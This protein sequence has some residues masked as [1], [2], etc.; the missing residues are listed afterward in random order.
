MKI[1]IL[2]L[3]A[4]I[5]FSGVFIGY[6]FL[7][8]A[9]ETKN[10][11]WG[12]NF[13]QKQAQN[14]GLEW[15]ETY[16]A[17][18][19]DLKIKNL[20][21]ISHW[22]LIEPKQG[23]YNFE[24]LDWQVN[25]A[26]KRGVKILLVVGIKTGRWPEC[27]APEWA[28]AQNEKRKSQNYLLEY[29]G[30]I[31]KRYRG[32]ASVSSWQAENEPF[33]PFGE[34]SGI[35]KDFLKK[36]I[37]QIKSLD[38]QKR[39]VVISDSGEFSFWLAAAELG[40]RVGTTLHRKVWFKEL[41]TYIQYPLKPVFYWRRAQLIEKL[42]GKEVFVAELQAE[43]WCQVFLSDCKPKEQ[44]KTMNL[45][46]FRGNIE[47]AKKTGLS[48]VYLWGSEWWYWLKTEQGQSSIW[49]EAKKLF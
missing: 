48:E 39:P 5:I 17:L 49:D 8:S 14:L 34:C 12:I 37:A 13:S 3:L 15:K 4:L 32:R 22:D 23:E 9:P 44:A 21:L 42:F 25:E 20:K 29:L 11:K 28:Q 33:F 47:F 10:I 1:A 46:R 2:F 31:V 43:P 19:D 36:E 27:H 16:L 45:E 40:D 35:D 26:E 41:G 6:L 24:D 30:T 18:L 7:G 38:F